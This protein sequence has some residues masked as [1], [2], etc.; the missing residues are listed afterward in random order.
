MLD[1]RKE[2]LKTSG[3][4]NLS[5]KVHANAKLTRVKSVLTDG[6]IKIDVAKPPED[7]KANIELIDFLA[8]EFGVNK[9]CI[10]IMHGKFSADKEVIIKK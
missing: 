10:S 2:Q 4:V 5:V 9:S 7:N 6:T 3:Q 1:S 8:R